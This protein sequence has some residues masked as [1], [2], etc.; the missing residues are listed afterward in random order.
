MRI[1]L[2]GA[3]GVIGRRLVP[4]LVDAGH[5]VTGMTRTPEHAAL[6]TELGAAAVVCDVYDA[7][8]LSAAVVAAQPDV[9]IHQL[10]DLPDDTSLIADYAP[11]NARIR[12]EGTAN[13]LAAASAAG[14]TRFIAQSVA[15][16]LPGPGAAG[17][18]AFEQTVLDA[19]GIVV[20]YGQFYGP[21]TYHFEP[22]PHPRIHID[23]AASRTLD[24]LTT[25]ESILTLAD[26]PD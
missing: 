18:R 10:T 6:L 2:A 9:V 15:W 14:A 23:D 16:E 22:P 3:T 13:L 21:G 12:R 11:R 20:R 1:F 24:A 17:I 5:E 8:S 19:S 25:D 26:A 4:L 7:S